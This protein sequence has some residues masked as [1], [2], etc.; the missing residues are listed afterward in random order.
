MYCC[1]NILRRLDYKYLCLQNKQVRLVTT[2]FC[3]A[4]RCVG[5]QSA[6]QVSRQSSGLILRLG[7]RVQFNT[8]KWKWDRGGGW[9]SGGA[10]GWGTAPEGRLFDSLLGH[11]DF[12]L[13]QPVTVMSPWGISCGGK[14]RRGVGLITLSPFVPIFYKF[15]EPQHTGALRAC[16]RLYKDCLTLVDLR[17]LASWG[18]GFESRRGHGCLPL[19][20]VVCC[21]SRGLCEGP[22]YLLEEIARVCVYVCESECDQV[23][24]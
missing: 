9:E 6:P 2:P 7:F 20:N 14:G 21:V 24:Q 10:I 12:S 16:P 1:T 13:T 17:S 19:V 5:G 23:Q 11:W 4:Q 8:C 15:W 3:W 22:I 18:C